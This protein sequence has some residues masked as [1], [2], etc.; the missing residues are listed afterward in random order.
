MDALDKRILTSNPMFG[1][2][3]A[4]DKIVINDKGKRNGRELF[5]WGGDL[6]Y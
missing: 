6:S 2:N 1:Y 4:D 5:Y 3:Y